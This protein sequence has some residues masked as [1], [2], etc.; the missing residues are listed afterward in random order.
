M[1]TLLHHMY[2]IFNINKRLNR[3][4]NNLTALSVNSNLAKLQKKINILRVIRHNTSSRVSRLVLTDHR[5]RNNI[6]RVTSRHV[7]LVGNILT[8]MSNNTFGI[9]TKVIVSFLRTRSAVNRDFARNLNR[10]TIENTIRRTGTSQDIKRMLHFTTTILSHTQHHI[11][12]VQLTNQDLRFTRTR[13]IRV[14]R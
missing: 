4:V 2:I 13:G 14:R 7:H 3:T 6:N 9:N 11:T 5:S 12:M 8:R 1:Y 10:L